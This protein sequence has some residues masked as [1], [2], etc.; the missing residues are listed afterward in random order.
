MHINPYFIRS[1]ARRQVRTWLYAINRI[2]SW[3]IDAGANQL[4]A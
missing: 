3:I 4:D 2:G 1:G